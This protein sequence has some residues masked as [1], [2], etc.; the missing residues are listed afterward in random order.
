MESSCR[1]SQTRREVHVSSSTG[2][3]SWELTLA[4]GRQSRPV[5]MH[6]EGVDGALRLL[7]A[8]SSA[9]AAQNSLPAA[10][11]TQLGLMTLMAGGFVVVVAVV[12]VNVVPIDAS[13]SSWHSLR[14]GMPAISGKCPGATRHWHSARMQFNHPP[15]LRLQQSCKQRVYAAS[16]LHSL[17]HQITPR[18]SRDH[19]P[20]PQVRFEPAALGRREVRVDDANT[21]GQGA[22]TGRK[23]VESDVRHAAARRARVHNVG[24]HAAR[25]SPSAGA[26]RGRQ[27]PLDP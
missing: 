19:V 22:V 11:S 3:C 15:R 24:L 2:R 7:L 17:H 5:G 4:T 9:R 27:G 8:C 12:A 25:A 18:E 14:L 20:A 10:C 23:L 16:T 13:A 1:K 21:S 6:G 26:E